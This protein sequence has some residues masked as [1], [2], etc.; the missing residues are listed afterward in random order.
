LVDLAR[1]ILAGEPIDLTMGYV[2]VIWQGDANAM[3]LQ[4]LVHGRSPAFALNIAGPE[5]I[6]VRRI[7]E[8]L[9]ELLGR[10]PIF[11]GTEDEQALLSNGRLGCELFGQPQVS[12]EQLCRWIAQWL[13]AGGELLGKPTKFQV[14]DGKF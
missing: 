3:A 5:T 9:G 2:N 8:Q 1:Q 4:S 14:R 13:K 12:I 10:K 11:T 7:C 6:S